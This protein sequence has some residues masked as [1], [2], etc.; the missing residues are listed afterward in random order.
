MKRGEEKGSGDGRD[1]GT[2]EPIKAILTH[3]IIILLHYKSYQ[4]N[5]IE[6]L[7]E[8]A[9]GLKFVIYSIRI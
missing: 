8:D 7:I 4:N 6:R 1:W 5:K 9:F 3:V 2:K